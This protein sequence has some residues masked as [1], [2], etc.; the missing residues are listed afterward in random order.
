MVQSTG[1]CYQATI[2]GQR[3]F[4]QAGYLWRHHRL[5]WD[6]HTHTGGEG[7]GEGRLSDMVDGFAVQSDLRSPS[8]GW[9]RRPT[10]AWP[11]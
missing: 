2:G 6:S 10:G 5:T 4:T 7:T 1:T 3:R 11:L 9:A 8:R